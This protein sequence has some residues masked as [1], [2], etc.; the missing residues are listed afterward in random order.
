MFYLTKLKYTKKSRHVWKIKDNE[1]EGD[2]APFLGEWKVNIEGTEP[3]DFFMH[4][5]PEELIDGIVLKSN[6][7]ALLFFV[8]SVMLYCTVM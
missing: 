1:F 8:G 2:L 7:Y 3:I 5:F 4:L 6:L